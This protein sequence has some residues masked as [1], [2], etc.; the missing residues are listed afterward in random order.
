VKGEVVYHIMNLFLRH[1]FAGPPA[2]ELTAS[3]NPVPPGARR[4]KTTISWSSDSA[5][6]AVYVSMNGAEEK[7]FASGS[8]GSEE[9]HWIQTGATY[10]FSLYSGRDRNTRLARISV[11]RPSNDKRDTL[12]TAIRS[13]KSVSLAK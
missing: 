3:P 2:T 12:R 5:S 10:E 11:T 1:Y 9:A 6:A 4:G 7:F 13:K 8:H